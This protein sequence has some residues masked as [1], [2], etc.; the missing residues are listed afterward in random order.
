[1]PAVYRV[2]SDAKLA[3]AATAML[4]VLST[5]I[6]VPIVS[7]GLMTVAVPMIAYAMTR[8]PL[9]HSMLGLMFFAL[10]LPNPAEGLPWLPWTA[11]FEHVGALLLNHWNTLDRSAGW[12]SPAVFSGVDLF[13]VVLGYVVYRR[14]KSRSRLDYL[15]AVPSPAPMRRLARISLATTGFTWMMGLLRGGDFRMSLWQVNGVIYLPVIFLLFSEAIRGP[16]DFPA[17]LRV[18]CA[19]AVARALI[20]FFVIHTFSQPPDDNGNTL[21][22]YATSHSDSIL[23]ADAFLSVAILLVERVVRLRQWRKL[24]VLPVFAIG[25]V[26]NNRRLVWIHIAISMLVLYFVTDDNPVKRKVRRLA[27]AMVPIVL[28]YAALGWNSEYGGFYKPI[29]LLRSVADAKAD[30]TGS[31]FWRE[32]ENLN[33][34]AT[35][36]E[37]QVFG[38]G[39]GHG[40][41]ELAKLPAVTYDLERFVPHNSLLGLW[42]YSGYIG[43]AGTT[44]LWVVGVYYAMRAYRNSMDPSIRAAAL[45]S[46]ICVLVYLMH[47]W[48]DLGLGCWTGVFTAGAALAVAGKAAEAAARSGVAPIA[49]PQST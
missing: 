3:L 29:R 38:T 2:R 35:L 45:T 12:M 46:V 31:S 15:D 21:L 25:M 18:L 24:W 44:M 30:P 49:P 6:G 41:V 14:R 8:M 20:A 34:I 48:G 9:R 1:M 7:V 36:R 27:I 40:F 26:S 5:L 16:Q 10:T 32:L 19:A 13:F 28:S 33:L 47:S 17:V 11:P 4:A 43:Y 39:Y 42:A 23:F 22:P 37:N